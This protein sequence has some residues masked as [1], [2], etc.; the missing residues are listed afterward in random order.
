MQLDAD[1]C[2]KSQDKLKNLYRINYVIIR[3]YFKFQTT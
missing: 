2:D 3:F 1:E